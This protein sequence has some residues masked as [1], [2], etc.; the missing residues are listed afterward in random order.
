MGPEAGELPRRRGHL[1]VLVLWAIASVVLVFTT[2][3]P[4]MPTIGIFA[5]GA[6]LDVYRDG[7][8]HVMED[9]PLYTEPVI[10]GLLYTYTPF[11]TLMFIPFGLLPGGIDKYIWMGANLVLLVAIVA[12][13][14]RMLGYRITPYLVGVSALLA[15]ACT[16]L[17][18]VRTTLFY[19]QI[20]LVLMALV[21]WDVSRGENSK[22][23]GVGVG[24]A[25]GIKL[26]PAYFVLYYL[27]LRQW[28]AAAVAVGTI[29]AT[30]GAS[31]LV[32]P[33]DS[34]QYWT[35][36]FFESTRIAQDEH[37]SNQSIRGVIAHLTGKPAPT[38]LW[39][40]LAAIVV[41][42]SM[43][44]VLRLHRGGEHLLAVTVAGLSA[45]AVSPFSWSHHWV[46]F[47]PLLVYIVHR[48]LTNWWWWLAALVIAVATGAW[49]YRW[50]EYVVVVG[51]FLFPP[52][53]TVAD[54]LMNIYILLYVGVLIGAGIVAARCTPDGVHDQVPAAD[55]NRT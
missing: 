33:N 4:W 31:W 27:V 38:V 15:V 25:A 55:A 29:A 54:V 11:S 9:L 32:L 44:I 5:G 23:K 6:D 39:V 41:V 48:A 30:I 13:C 2:V 47:V 18:P 42:V 7:A 35:K 51:L 49:P 45:A 10:H 40:V 50:D 17:E 37:P 34:W 8:R 19:G 36:T 28:R 14:W 21:L 20:N 43:W 26:T 12:L 22:L 52:W 1:A 53:W 16:F 46:W 24:I 3:R